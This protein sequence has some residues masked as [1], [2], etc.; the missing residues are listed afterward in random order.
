[1]ISE[2]TKIILA[3]DNIISQ[4]NEWKNG[5]FEDGMTW[6]IQS[7]LL[8]TILRYSPEHSSFIINAKYI[9]ERKHDQYEN[10]REI[11]DSEK[12]LRDIDS[13]FGVLLARKTAY[14]NDILI[15]IQ[16]RIHADIFEDFIEIAESFL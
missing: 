11:T 2:K 3:I 16:Q 14:E 4:Y 5:N 10:I 13:L 1:M 6:R 7:L 8:Q 15:S 12:L 9:V